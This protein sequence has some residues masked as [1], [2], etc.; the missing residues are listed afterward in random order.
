MATSELDRFWELANKTHGIRP[1]LRSVAAIV[2]FATEHDVRLTPSDL[3]SL[4]ARFGEGVCPPSIARFIVRLLDGVKAQRVLDPHVGFGTLLQ[5]VI[6]ATRASDFVATSPNQS[7]LEVAEYVHPTAAGGEYCVCDLEGEGLAHLGEFD[8]VVSLPPFGLRN[9]EF[10]I[11]G[12]TLRDESGHEL[13]LRSSLR[14]SAKGL[15][16]FVV[17]PRFHNA[18]N[19]RSVVRRLADFGLYLDASFHVAPGAFIPL[20]SI[21]ADIVVIRRGNA[22]TALFAGQ[23]TEQEQPLKAL[24]SN[25]RHRRPG[26][27][28]DL[29][30]LI[31]HADYRGF[32]AERSK[33]RIA[34]LTKRLKLARRDLDYFALEITR[35][36]GHAEEIEDKDNAFFLPLI[37]TSRCRTDA[38]ELPERPKDFVQI[39][40]DP[41][42][43]DSNVVAGFF[44]S[45]LGREIRASYASG[46]TIR[47]VPLGTVAHLPVW[48]PDVKKQRTI[49]KLDQQ[50]RAILSEAKELHGRLW[51]GLN[52][53]GEVRQGVEQLNRDDTFPAWLDTLPFPLASILWT[54]HT[55]KGS[56]LKRY[57]QLEFFFEGLA[58]FLGIWL[59]S[60]I[61][62]APDIFQTEWKSIR[63][64]LDRAKLSVEQATFG[65]WVTIV[66]RL[67]KTVRSG[68]NGKEDE[69]RFWQAKFA[70]DSPELMRSLVSKSM[71]GLTKT[72]NK[73]RNDWRGHGG[74]VSDTEAVRRES[75][76]LELRARFRD[77]VGHRWEDYPLVFPISFRFP[78]GVYRCDVF[79]VTGVRYPFDQKQLDLEAPLKDG[80]LHFVNPMTGAVCPVLP[81]VRLG[82]TATEERNACYFFNRLEGGDSQRYVSYHFEDRPDIVEEIPAAAKLLRELSL[83]D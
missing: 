59:M 3:W 11:E 1:D 37:V 39:V 15:A 40:V 20:T 55:L 80:W 8:L 23:A 74:V 82:T 33:H 58:E 83:Q 38:A 30:V 29:G 44:D 50:L 56:P 60:G 65:T 26:P 62:T 21:A 75:V 77:L 46:I 9:R 14:L 69:R 41:E 27:T 24:L 70:C 5:P 49:V 34:T 32:E 45:P 36:P 71:V 35:C 79:S 42:K 52:R 63:Q 18:A 16:I 76:L 28:P 22:A 51:E 54:H 78:D 61:K 68:V 6:A 66:E 64:T 67:A 43:A 10:T 4:T 25:Y 47:R 12:V 2:Q 72:A 81:L 53:T 19:E 31:P 17:A 73:L 48:L 13:L 7:A 57:Q